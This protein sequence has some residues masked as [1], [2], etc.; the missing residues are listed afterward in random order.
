MSPFFFNACKC[1]L[2]LFVLFRFICLIG[3]DSLCAW[4]GGILCRSLILYLCT[5][6]CAVLYLADSYGRND[7]YE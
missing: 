2:L 6:G 7:G 3:C 5:V 4:C 1:H